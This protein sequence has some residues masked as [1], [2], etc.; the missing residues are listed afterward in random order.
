MNEFTMRTVVTKGLVN[1]LKNQ[2]I[3]AHKLKVMLDF[4]ENT[5][6]MTATFVKIH[7]LLFEKT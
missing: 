4:V 2:L 1:Q 7:L 3:A 5:E 6:K